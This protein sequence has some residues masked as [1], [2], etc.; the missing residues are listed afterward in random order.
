MNQIG[1][2]AW[3]VAHRAAILALSIKP[4]EPAVAADYDRL[5]L[6]T[7]EFHP[8]KAAISMSCPR[9]MRDR[10]D[11]R[12]RRTF[13]AEVSEVACQFPNSENATLVNNQ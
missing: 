11:I 8:S 7:S 1:W 6:R 2:S 12:I 5:R 13:Y 10:T 4:T 3:I 9:P